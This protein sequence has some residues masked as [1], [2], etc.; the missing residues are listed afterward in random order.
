MTKLNA[1]G[2]SFPFQPPPPAWTSGA[3]SAGT[4]L[5]FLTSLSLEALLLQLVTYFVESSKLTPTHIS[6]MWRVTSRNY[7]C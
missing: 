2:C 1:L 3:F 5:D 7:I 4:K 6:L